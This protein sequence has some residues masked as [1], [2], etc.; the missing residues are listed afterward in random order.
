MVNERDEQGR[1]KYYRSGKGNKRHADWWCVNS[2]R[3]IR[4]GDPFRIPPA[5]VAN[6]APCMRC[7][8]PSELA[9]EAAEVAT[10]PAETKCRNS[11]VVLPHRLYSKCVDCGKE[12]SVN[13]STGTLRA[14]K[15]LPK[16]EVTL[17]GEDRFSDAL[18]AAMD[19]WP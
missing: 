3:K 6:W 13:R 8:D 5:E 1:V 15:P 9:K 19:V 4:T 10:K 18:R 14:H 11:G 16:L 7:C 2:L 12:G 17:K